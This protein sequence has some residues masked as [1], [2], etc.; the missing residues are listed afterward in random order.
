[1]DMDISRYWLRFPW[2]MTMAGAEQFAH[3]LSPVTSGPAARMLVAP[4]AR[5]MAEMPAVR[6][7]PLLQ[8]FRNKWD[9][10][11]VV[12]NSPREIVPLKAWVRKAY[13]GDSFQTPWVI[14]GIGQKYTEDALAQGKRINQLF[15]ESVNDLPVGAWM[16][17]HA[18]MGLALARAALARLPSRPSAEAVRATLQEF[19]ALCRTSSLPGYAGAALESL[20]LVTRF[21]YGSLVPMVDRELRRVDLDVLSYFW[22]GVGRAIYFLPINFVPSSRPCRRDFEMAKIEPPHEVGYLNAIA[23]LMWAITLV[24]LRQPWIIEAA[25]ETNQGLLPAGGA[26][27]NGVFSVT[28]MRC[29]VIAGDALVTA[30]HNYSP[31]SPDPEFLTLWRENVKVP[32][33]RALRV[34]VGDPESLF[35]FT[36]YS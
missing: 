30:L 9:V 2:N 25:L 14:E 26:F 4:V 28:C 33:E 12:E 13:Q 16:M 17:L 10:I 6:G 8:E 7:G 3:A 27:A 11:D 19:F 24:N 1:M 23:G 22:H 21:S 35:E 29:A 15:Q 31:E 32:A 18:G 20:G 5:L 36:R 34:A